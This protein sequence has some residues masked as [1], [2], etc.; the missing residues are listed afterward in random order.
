M[1]RAVR[2]S[3]MLFSAFIAGLLVYA[4]SFAATYVLRPEDHSV[5]VDQLSPD[6]NMVYKTGMVVASAEDGN[7]R[8]VIHFNLEGWAPDSISEASL[9][10]W[11]LRGGGYSDQR[12]VE[13]YS[14]TTAFHESTATWNSPW[15]ASGGDYDPGLSASADVP[16]AWA[17]W[18]E[19][20]V[21][22]IVKTKW[23]NVSTNG[24]LLKDPVEDSPEE[25]YIKFHSH[26][27]DSLPYL[28]IVTGGTDVQQAADDHHTRGFSLEQNF[29]NPFN[30]T[31][32]VR[33]DLLNSSRVNLAVYNI[34]GQKVKTLVDAEKGAGTHA[35]EWDGTDQSGQSVA[36]GVYLY[37]LQ[38]GQFSETK[39]LLYLK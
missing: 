28:Q 1:N 38:A 35:L 19:W 9:Y 5:Q 39:R 25:P 2:V 24:F 7:A 23:D 21:T 8:I 32:L 34:L 4:H 3:S 17:N 14:L 36:S 29:P 37:R 27:E 12:P 30:N 20:D 16:Q 10:L 33:F 6:E 15:T 11:H 31:T 26:R 22:E 18:V 13:I